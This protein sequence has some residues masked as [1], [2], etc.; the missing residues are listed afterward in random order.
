MPI[1]DST[2]DNQA[3]QRVQAGADET[4]YAVPIG[5]ERQSAALSELLAELQR[6]EHAT[7]LA[8]Q[9][10][11]A[12]NSGTS[13]AGLSAELRDL[14]PQLPAAERAS[15]RAALVALETDQQTGTPSP[16]TIQHIVELLAAQVYAGDELD[17]QLALPL[18][19]DSPSFDL[20]FSDGDE[21]Y[22]GNAGLVILWPFLADFFARLGLLEGLQFKDRAA[23]QCAV[24]LLQHIATG[25]MACPEYLL[26][27]NKL[28]CGM[29]LA[30][31]FDP[32]EPLRASEIA[33]CGDLLRSTIAQVPILRDM[34]VAGFQS[35]F[36][37]RQAVLSARDGGW[38]LRVER[39]TYD[40]VLD[41]FPW[42]WQWLKL[43]WMHA[44]LRVEW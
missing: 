41:H 23:Q 6:V 10:C 36:L 15:L 26:P 39:Q 32:G 4:N 13:L 25:D 42:G 30:E 28:L 22:I 24:W 2:A 27:L 17:H 37:L 33:A 12:A 16:K 43:P 9:I 31:L 20:S 38:L 3:R 18:A 29:E 14:I 8:W 21:L 34:S 40:L 5:L 7:A 1:P 44:P 19:A 35:T 11:R